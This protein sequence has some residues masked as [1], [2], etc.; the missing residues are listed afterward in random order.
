MTHKNNNSINKYIYNNNINTH[1]ISNNTNISNNNNNNK[2][3]IQSIQ[4]IQ[5]QSPKNIN[6]KYI[7]I[8][9]K[10]N[11]NKYNGFEDD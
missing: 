10:Y 6:N 7:P 8:N 1:N 4:N 5:I 2:T 3:I 11:N 9:N